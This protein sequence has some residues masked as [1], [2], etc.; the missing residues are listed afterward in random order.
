[1]TVV[2]HL[3]GPWAHLNGRDLDAEAEAVWRLGPNNQAARREALLEWY[4]GLFP[5]RWGHD[6]G[7][8]LDALLAVPIPCFACPV[9]QSPGFW[10]SNGRGHG[11]DCLCRGAGYLGFTRHEDHRHIAVFHWGQDQTWQNGE[12]FP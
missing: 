1:M 11:P 8:S 3:G 5:A 4:Q 2:T 9:P 6:D 10:S 12:S 7:P